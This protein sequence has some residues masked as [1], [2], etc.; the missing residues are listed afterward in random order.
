[1][2]EVF[3]SDSYEMDGAAAARVLW[4]GWRAMWGTR[5]EVGEGRW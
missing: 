2:R 3:D 5:V 4:M 1:M